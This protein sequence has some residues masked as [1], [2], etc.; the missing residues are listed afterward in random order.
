MFSDPLLKKSIAIVDSV[1]EKAGMDY[2]DLFLSR[3]LSEK[4]FRMFLLSNIDSD[5][6]KVIVKNIFKNAKLTGIAS[7]LRIFSGTIFSI[8][9]LKKQKVNWIIFHVFR[10]DL[11][12]LFSSLMARL[13]GFKV[14]LIIHDVES[15]DTKTSSI[16]AKWVL[17][18]FHD[19][20]IVHN[21]FSMQELKKNISESSGKNIY[22]IPHGNFIDVVQVQYDRAHATEYLKLDP[23]K[24]YLLFF[25]QIKRLKGW[26]F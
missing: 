11:I 9:F 19:I 24:K 18:K 16:T 10:G 22:T 3:A 7:V 23:E 25:G 6:S 20:K 17:E 5:E 26:I 4:G 15:L 8:I 21:E 13:F 1:G 14:L 2:Y 12:E